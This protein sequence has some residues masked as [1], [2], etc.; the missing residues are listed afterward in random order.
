LQSRPEIVVIDDDP[1]ALTQI[2]HSLETHYKVH[3]CVSP[4]SAENVIR[5]QDVELALLDLNLGARSGLQTLR[6]WRDRYPWVKTVFCSG[7]SRPDAIAECLKSGALD[8]IPK[9]VRQDRLLSALQTAKDTGQA[10]N[11]APKKTRRRAAEIPTQLGGYYW[12]PSR[13]SQALLAKA[14]QLRGHTFANVLI[15]GETGTGK[16]GL[17]RYLH[18]SELPAGT[19]PFVA[20]NLSAL[21]I[22]LLESELFG[23]E[24]GAYTDAKASRAGKLEQAN[25]GDLFL[26]EV[27]DLP[28][29]A[30]AKLLRVLQEKSF[31]RLGSSRVHC[32]AF[33]TIAATHQPLGRWA[34]SGRFREDLYFRLADVVLRIAPLRDR[35]EDILPLA[36]RFL[37]K[38]APAEGLELS[39]SARASLLEHRSF[40]RA[41]RSIR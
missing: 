17:A 33:R 27:G 24:R 41:L 13:A 35:R 12:G 8:F 15:L 21:P 34:R 10:R 38:H 39:S 31:E 23:V 36:E 1:L 9:P 19:R 22:S 11:Q 20:L 25:G 29:A 28:L 5:S 2:Y 4:Q 3:L 7:D 40:E 18:H 6:K 37:R 14:N 16:E 30:Q 26:D 32:S